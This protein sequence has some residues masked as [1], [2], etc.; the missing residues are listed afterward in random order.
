MNK[1]NFDEKFLLLINV[2]LT[3]EDAFKS[4]MYNGARLKKARHT[5]RETRSSLHVIRLAHSFPNYEKRKLFVQTR[6][7]S[8]SLLVYSRA[9]LEH[10][11]TPLYDGLK[12]ELVYV[13]T[14][15]DTA[16][17]IEPIPPFQEIKAAWLKTPQLFYTWRRQ[18]SWQK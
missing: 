9:I 10:A 2:I 1:I 7:Q 16:A 14:D 13:L 5:W 11:K 12:E 17:S 18:T 15:K 6:L 8:L 4:S 3:I